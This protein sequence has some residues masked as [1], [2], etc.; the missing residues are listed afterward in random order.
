[1]R[2]KATIREAHLRS[3]RLRVPLLDRGRRAGRRRAS[4]LVV[5]AR[6]PPHRRVRARAAVGNAA[7]PRHRARGRA[8]VDGHVRGRRA[9]GGARRV[10]H[11]VAAARVRGGRRA[12]VPR[13]CGNARPAR[14]DRGRC[15]RA[16]VSARGA[17]P[18]VARERHRAR[19][20]GGR[21]LAVGR[22]AARRRRPAPVARAS[23]E[24]IVCA[25][26]V[27]DHMATI[28]ITPQSGAVWGSDYR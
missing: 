19:G 12:R 25:G 17:G 23:S 1:M 28:T 21:R 27:G 6:R 16:G 24:A 2:N 10:R 5:R 13:R 22:A 4:A 8:A 3:A 7:R 15:R 20:G 18:V 9:R 11:A 14:G 26:N